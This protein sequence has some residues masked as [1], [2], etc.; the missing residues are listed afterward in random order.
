MIR[1]EQKKNFEV[2]SVDFEA[3]VGLAVGTGGSGGLNGDRTRR[4]FLGNDHGK[5]LHAALGPIVDAGEDGV[6]VVEIVVE[7]GDER[8][9]EGESLFKRPSALHLESDFGGAVGK[10]DVGAV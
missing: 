6:L 9:V 10:G 5:S 8:G 7:N 4:Q 3:F 2:G 1:V